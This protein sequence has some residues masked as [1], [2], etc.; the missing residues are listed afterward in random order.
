MNVIVEHSLRP[1]LKLST[2]WSTDWASRESVAAMSP[3][4][5]NRV[6]NDNEGEQSQN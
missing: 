1:V 2:W 4:E 6:S 3:P 5:L